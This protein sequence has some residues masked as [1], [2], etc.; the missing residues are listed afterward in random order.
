VIGREHG[1]LFRRWSPRGEK[2]MLVSKRRE[3]G[4]EKLEKTQLMN[5][6]LDK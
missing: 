2:C 3:K 5:A 1:Q 4:R 6:L